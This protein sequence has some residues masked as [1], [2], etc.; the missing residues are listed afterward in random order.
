MSGN[1]QTKTDEILDEKKSTASWDIKEEQVE[2]I[3]DLGQQKIDDDDLFTNDIQH[4]HEDELDIVNVNKIVGTTDDTTL[5]CF[6]L[7]AVLVAT[8][9]AALSSS[10]SQLMFFKPVGLALSDTFMI[11][12]AYVVCTA[13][14]VFLPKGGWLNPFPFNSK[15]FACIYVAVSSANVSSYATYILSAQAL[16]Y[17]NPPSGAGAIFLIF[18]TQLVGYGIA[19]QLRSFLVYPA[20]MIWPM[21]LPTVSLIRTLTSE[22]DEARWRT[23][24][25]FIVFAIAFIYAFIPEYMFPLLGGFSIFCLAKDDSA[26]FTRLFGG[27]G[28][29]E[30]LG[31]LS[32]SFDWNFLSYYYPMVLPL[33]VQLNIYFGILLL[34]I[35]GPILWYYDVW[36]AQSF[37]FL[38]N[39]IFAMNETTHLGYTYPQKSVLNPDNSLNHTKLEEVG[40]PRYSTIFALSYILINFGVTAT[41]THVA[42]YY[43]KQIW[44]TVRTTREEYAKNNQDIHNKLMAA[45][46]EVPNWWYYIVFVLGIAVNIGLAYANHSSLPAWGVIF[47]VLVSTVLSLPLNMVEAITG[48]GF[49]LNVLTEMICGFVLP[50]YPVANMYF[51]T[52]GYNTLNQAGKMGKDLKVGHYL[53]VP[54]KMI[55]TSQIFGTIIGSIFNYI[56]ND[57]VVTT[58]RDI[59][60]DPDGGNNIW[61][62][63]SPQTINSAAITWGAIGPMVMFGPESQYYIILW[64][65]V[66]GFFLPIPGWLLHKKFP[67]VGF[68]YIN[69][70]MI[71]VGFA[72]LPGTNSSWITVSFI[73]IIVTQGFVKRRYND[74]FV[75]YN[76]LTSAALDSGTSLMVFFLSMALFGG[77][78]G[79][80]YNFPVW[81]GNRI[82]IKYVDHCC[83]NCDDGVLI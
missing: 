15:E 22:K 3:N 47:A 21:T 64:A 19:G 70:P 16:Y 13:W 39:G 73:I 80:V 37:R 46:P 5:R 18:A 31:I 65:F 58:K 35:V 50:G 52:L 69:V 45:Y 9:L 62:G 7:R 11:M 44:S 12:V 76:Y 48:Q 55:F 74:W 26:W 75:K 49:G 78:S 24:F 56:V 14:S 57:N 10:V 41:I 43:G 32:L 34:W 79:N 72:T 53:K 8:G 28:V 33:W 81:W 1:L 66:I 71:L 82:D 4:M 42:L 54:P 27:S 68:N 20:N 6:S 29:N 25:F 67:K 36:D 77:G 2:P 23:R 17:D 59:L 51:K 61:S 30:G 63:A 60:L 40:S 83:M 38:S